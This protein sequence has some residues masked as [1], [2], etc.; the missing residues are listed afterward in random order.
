MAWTYFSE[1]A[2]KFSCVVKRFLA[3]GPVRLGGLEACE[4]ELGAEMARL[5]GK[6]VLDRG[7]FL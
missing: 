7:L 5:S 1:S 4:P 2:N 3:L 6:G